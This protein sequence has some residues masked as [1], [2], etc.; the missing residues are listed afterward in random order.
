M[1]V[2]HVGA[3]TV[4]IFLVELCVSVPRDVF[5]DRIFLLPVPHGAFTEQQLFGDVDSRLAGGIAALI[6]LMFL[7]AFLFLLLR[8]FRRRRPQEA[9]VLPSMA[10]GKPATVIMTQPSITSF[11]I[12]A[13]FSCVNKPAGPVRRELRCLG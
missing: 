11:F 5:A 12:V 8:F 3:F 10:V 2:R 6:L 4:S 13:V 1:T 9:E 7:S